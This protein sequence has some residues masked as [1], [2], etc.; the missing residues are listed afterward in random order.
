MSVR[1]F[2]DATAPRKFVWLICPEGLPTKIPN[3]KHISNG[4]TIS[5]QGQVILLPSA[6]A[7]GWRVME[8]HCSPK[9]WATWLLYVEQG[10]KVG[11]RI[12]KLADE[13]VPECVRG[14][15]GVPGNDAV[16]KPKIAEFEPG[17]PLDELAESEPE[18]PKV[19][20]KRVLAPA[21]LPK[22]DAI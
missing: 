14:T 5:V 7:D 18:A 13:F 19:P 15:Y 10:D 21:S 6:K 22:G 12:A 2:T 9:E 4:L 20:R 17:S 3:E 16:F 11:W 1:A 8:E